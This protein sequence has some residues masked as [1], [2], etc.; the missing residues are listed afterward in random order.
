MVRLTVKTRM[1]TDEELRK[2]LPSPEFFQVIMK[3]EA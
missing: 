1:T 2:S 3:I